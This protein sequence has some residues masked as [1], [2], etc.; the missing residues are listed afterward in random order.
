[1]E[2]KNEEDE[3]K[4]NEKF[5]AHKAKATRHLIL[6]RHGQYNLNGISDTERVLTELGTFFNFIFILLLLNNTW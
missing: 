1:M 2:I 4:Y 3:N 5:E 6:I